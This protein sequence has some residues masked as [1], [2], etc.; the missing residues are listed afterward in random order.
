MIHTISLRK[1]NGDSGKWEV[2]FFANY[3]HVHFRTYV[4]FSIAASDMHAWCVDGNMPH[5]QSYIEM[6]GM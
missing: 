1:L 4:N 3:Q 6:E 5:A 2:D